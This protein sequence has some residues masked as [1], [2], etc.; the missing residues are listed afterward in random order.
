MSERRIFALGD[1]GKC[2]FFADQDDVEHWSG[3]KLG[4]FEL[5]GNKFLHKEDLNRGD[6]DEERNVARLGV[7][8]PRG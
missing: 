3:M 5:V 4:S 6:D 8:K 7:R 2:R 1:P